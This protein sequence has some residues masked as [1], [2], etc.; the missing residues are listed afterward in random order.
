LR[1]APTRAELDSQAFA[2]F[3]TAR[4]DDGTAATGFHANQKA[5]GTGAANFRGL[6][7]AFHFKFLSIQCL[8]APFV[9]LFYRSLSKMPMTFSGK[10][11]QKIVGSLPLLPTFG[12]WARAW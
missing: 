3:G 2:A 8:G 4:V 10:F 12:S 1:T 9:D 6:V 11:A 7:R 5:V